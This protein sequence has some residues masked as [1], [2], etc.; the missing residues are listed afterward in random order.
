MD[1]SQSAIT[2]RKSV[3][4]THRTLVVHEH[5]ALTA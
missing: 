4:A 3:L 2:S 5:L 1:K